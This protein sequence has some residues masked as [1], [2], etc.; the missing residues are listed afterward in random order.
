MG[1]EVG[2]VKSHKED[3]AFNGSRLEVD[4]ANTPTHLSKICGQY[5]RLVQEIEN[6]KRTTDWPIPTFKWIR[7][8]PLKHFLLEFTVPWSQIPFFW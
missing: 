2:E 8:F 6:E 7:F 1:G 5:E 4:N 3:K